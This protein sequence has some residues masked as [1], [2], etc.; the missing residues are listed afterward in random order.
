MKDYPYMSGSPEKVAKKRT[1]RNEQAF[2]N[3]KT[4][5][6]ESQCDGTYHWVQYV[7][8]AFVLTVKDLFLRCRRR[9]LAPWRSV[10]TRGCTNRGQAFTSPVVLDLFMSLNVGVLWQ[11]KARTTSLC[12]LPVSSCRLPSIH[13]VGI[14]LVSF[15]EKEKNTFF[16]FP[17]SRYLEYISKLI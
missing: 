3:R 8:L 4:A 7:C 5:L 14:T 13:H 6:F 12:R 11:L 17:L 15:S 9:M 2:P 1:V 10:V 16:V